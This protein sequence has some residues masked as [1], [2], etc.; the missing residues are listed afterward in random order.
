MALAADV[1]LRP[2]DA[3]ARVAGVTGT[4]GKTTTTFLL[5]AILAAAGHRPGLLGTVERR[6][7][8]ERRR[9][10]HTPEAI[11]LQR[12]SARCWTQATAAARWRPLARAELGPARRHAL[13]AL[14]FTNLSQDHLDFHGTIEAYFDAEAAALRRARRRP[15]RPSTSATRWPPARRRAPSLG[16]PVT[17]GRATR[18]CGRRL[19]LLDAPRA[20]LRSAAAA[21][22]LQRRERPRRRRRVAPSRYRRRR[23]RGGRRA[24]RRRARPLRGGR[25]GPAVRRPRRLRAHSRG[26]RATCSRAARAWRRAACSASSAAAATATAPSAADGRGRRRA[27]R[28]GDRHVRQPAQRGSAAIIDEILAG[29]AGERRSSPTG[30]RAIA[31]ALEDAA[32]GDVVVIAGKGHEHGQEFAGGDASR[33]TTARSRARRSGGSRGAAMIPLHA[34]ARST[35]GSPGAAGRERARG[36][37]ASRA[38]RSTRGRDRATGDLFVAVGGGRRRR[39]S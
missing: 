29:C 22:A 2:P 23:D 15:R 1:V 33:S 38:S 16:E 9:H 25:R 27:R 18:T 36:A 39:S 12:P 31:R 21:R 4:N 10:A 6:I 30:A 5:D 24:R 26:A 34:R 3:R 32:A 8:G 37:G 11:D 17:F 14:V 28:P 20:R 19:E 7:G 35:S 13:R